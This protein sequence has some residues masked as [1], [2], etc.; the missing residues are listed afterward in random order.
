M[1]VTLI[2]YHD[3][4]NTSTRLAKSLND[5]QGVLP[6]L[7]LAYIASALEKVGHQVDL[8]DAIALC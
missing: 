6:P 8:I 2:R 3:L 1:K 7:G 4:D 5:R